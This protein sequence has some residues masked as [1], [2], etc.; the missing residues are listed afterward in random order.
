[1][2]RRI[3]VNGLI[4]F[5]LMQILGINSAFAK[6]IPMLTWER[7]QVRQIVL[8]GDFAKSNNQVQL[9]GNNGFMQP[10]SEQSDP[11]KDYKIYSISLAT[12]FELGTYAVQIIQSDGVIELAAGVTVVPLKTYQ[13]TRN[14]LDLFFI[15]LFFTFIMVSLSTSRARKYENLKFESTQ[16]LSNSQDVA[17]QA[18]HNYSEYFANTRIRLLSSFKT[19]L[20]KFLIVR[21]GELLYRKSKF[22]YA[23]AP[24]VG[25]I[26][27]LLV[28]I[29]SQ[30]KG[31]LGAIATSLLVVVAVF[32]LVD[33]MVGIFATLGF[34]S[35][36]FLSAGINSIR[37]ILIVASLSFI[38]VLPG[39]LSNFF[40]SFYEKDYAGLRD[41][42]FFNACV[43]SLFSMATI[44]TGMK[45]I[46]SV[47]ENVRENHI[48][49]LKSLV[50][51]GVISFVKEYA[52]GSVLSKAT[53]ESIRTDF[54]EFSVKRITS[55]SS[56]LAL[57]VL[58]DGFIYIWIGKA[59][60]AFVLGFLISLPLFFLFVRLTP[61]KSPI[62]GGIKR[63]MISEALAAS[64]IA[65]G[66]YFTVQRSPLLLDYKLVNTLAFSFLIIA[67]HAGL[68]L[69]IDSTERSLD[70]IQ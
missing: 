68:S 70:R 12:D 45:L 41:R 4:V 22:T 44:H 59:A 50:L 55:P 24:I 30:R 69:I 15:I 9:V 49:S 42:R 66:I 18:A 27:S 54:R 33:L 3:K 7:G 31:N 26:L 14:P 35:M 11:K 21:D 64:F 58:A 53:K 62:R 19:S 52:L 20:F 40:A 65:I 57:F 63:S 38:W 8:G 32:A 1:M 29:E 43:A 56:G 10:F 17:A 46:N 23:L 60:I 51:L 47:L 5:I 61:T 6:N 2:N 34:W 39:L 36:Q 67:V 25:F 28:T 48:I 13:V 16:L 37:D